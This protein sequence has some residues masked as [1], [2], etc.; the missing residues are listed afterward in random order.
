MPQIQ[1]V[2]GSFEADAMISLHFLKH[3]T[4]RPKQLCE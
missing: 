3:S 1:Q 2:R 4:L